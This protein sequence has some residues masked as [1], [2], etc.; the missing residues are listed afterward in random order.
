MAGAGPVGRSA[1]PPR[2]THTM[3]QESSATHVECVQK[4]NVKKHHG[5]HPFFSLFFE[6]SLLCSAL[7]CSA[8]LC[9]A[10][11]QLNLRAK[12]ALFID[13]GG[14]KRTFLALSPS[15]NRVEPAQHDDSSSGFLNKKQVE[16]AQLDF[17]KNEIEFKRGSRM[18]SFSQIGR[19]FRRFVIRVSLSVSGAC[20]YWVR[21]G[22]CGVFS[23]QLLREYLIMPGQHL[24]NK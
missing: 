19:F 23:R 10:L 20:A 7:L 16:P 6:L 18:K 5:F 15:Q 3:S 13:L 24:V 9:S 14:V 8:L 21:F 12:V 22:D 17:R 4:K 1:P 11:A 2:S